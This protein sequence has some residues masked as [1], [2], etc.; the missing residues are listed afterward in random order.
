MNNHSRRR[1]IRHSALGVAGV[2]TGLNTIAN[3]SFIYSHSEP[4]IMGGAPLLSESRWIKWPIW[5]PETDEPLVLEVLRSGVWSRAKLTDQFENEWAG[6]LGSKRCLTTVNGTN[7]LIV[8]LHQLGVG[9]GDEV[10]VTP[11]TFVATVQAILING[12]I[13]V[14]V[15]V[16]PDTYQMDP[17]K[18]EAKIT[19]KTKV[20]LPVHILGMP[21]DMNRIMK[22]ARKRNLMVLEDA[23]QAHLAEI[24][25][26]KVSTIGDAGC[27]SFQNSKNLAIGEGGAI[28]SDNDSF[29]DGCIAFHNLGYPKKIE[30]G[31]PFRGSQWVGGKTR[32]AEYQA[33]IGLV[34]MKRL[35]E[36]T[37]TRN[38]NADYLRTRLK[39]IPGIVP[40]R[41]YDDVTKAAYL[42][43]AFRY[44]QDLFKGLSRASFIKA[45]AAEGVPVSSGY[46]PLNVQPFIQ[47]AL[48]SKN[49][50]K[51]YSRKD[52]NYNDY[53]AENQCPE[54]DKLCSEAIWI[55]QNMLLGSKNDMEIIA[56]AIERIYKN[57][58]KIKNTIK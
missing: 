36:Q 19:N 16:D 48:E 39:S 34:Q 25:G 18:I 6:M 14:F 47:D 38:V 15:D 37:E 32:M 17:E 13:P 45:L 35:K 22:I 29:I 26:K 21:A 53:L 24:S 30:P 28:V 10:L 50:K 46:T 51:S 41:L 56:T 49:Y 23:C 7:A 54:N 20:I 2:L 43:F 44:K 1:F 58:E 3:E 33:A 9:A 40:H 55:T 42:L 27:F 12:A 57:A 31:V 4:A 8:A 11:Y 52:L 5:I